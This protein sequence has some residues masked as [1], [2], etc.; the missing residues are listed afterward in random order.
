[1]YMYGQKH[2]QVL[3]ML[4]FAIPFKPICYLPNLMIP[5]I[6]FIYPL[7]AKKLQSRGDKLVICKD[8]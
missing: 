4:P 8:V 1:M 6:S 7:C 2:I 3:I 5:F